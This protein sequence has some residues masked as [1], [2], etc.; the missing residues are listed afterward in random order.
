MRILLVTAHFPA[1]DVKNRKGRTTPFLQHYAKEWVALGHEVVIFHLMRSYPRLFYFFSSFIAHMGN[2][3]FEKYAASKE[4]LEKK[5]YEFEGVKIRRTIYKKYIPHSST[6]SKQIDKLKKDL[7]FTINSFNPEI[8]I[9]DCFDPVLQ[10][11]AGIKELY[12]F[13]FLQI[14]HNSDFSLIDNTGIQSAITKVDGWL[15]RSNAQYDLL[16]QAIGGDFTFEYMYSGIESFRLKETIEPRTAIERLLFVGALQKPKGL[17]TVFD[18]MSISTNKKL[19]LTIVGNGVD[20]EYF[21][22]RVKILDL[23]D[24]VLFE[25]PKPHDEVFNYMQKADA[26]VL[27]SHETF[28]MVYV[29]A[30]SQGCIPIGAVNE[31]IDGV[32]IDGENGFL[33]PLNNSKALAELF[34]SFESITSETVQR[35]SN[36][37]FITAFKMT[38]EKLAMNAALFFN[39]AIT[40]HNT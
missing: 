33:R 30:M 18:A 11:V 37:S 24:R 26:L 21:K 25:G 7:L 31:G 13:P 9:G 28:G 2:K 17:D 32:V 8:V 15:L 10:M 34:D 39:K 19:K 38:D 12:S 20:E 36:N 16:E 4:E 1:Y 3:R 29:E 27:I 23:E 22:N 14:V 35:M 5:E 40:R 6:S